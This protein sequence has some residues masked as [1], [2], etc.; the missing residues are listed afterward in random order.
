MSPEERWDMMP[1]TTTKGG[2]RVPS[3]LRTAACTARERQE[4][5]AAN[6][7]RIDRR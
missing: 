3:T 5:S 2:V 7:C 6:A 4:R 1:V